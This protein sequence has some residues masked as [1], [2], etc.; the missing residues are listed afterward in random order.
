MVELIPKQE[1]KPIFGQVFFLIVSLFALVGVAAAFFIVQ[2]LIH[3]AEEELSALEKKFA[4][5]TRPLEEALTAEV[6]NYQKETEI[7]KTVLDERKA[8]LPF[9]A[10]LER[11]THPNVVFQKLEGSGETGVFNLEGTAESFF[12]LEQQRL[13]WKKQGELESVLRDITFG[14]GESVGFQV[15]FSVKPE[16]LKPL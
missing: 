9:F 10:L 8:L 16:V 13:W 6:Q 1:Q 2:Q 12:A 3:G 15:E 4:Q 14:A 7:L 5:D 11:I